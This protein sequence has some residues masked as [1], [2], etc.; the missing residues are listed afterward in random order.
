MTDISF[1][2]FN[3]TFFGIVSIWLNKSLFDSL[4]TYFIVCSLKSCFSVLL[5]IYFGSS[6][7][8]IVPSPTKAPLFIVVLPLNLF[9]VPLLMKVQ[10]FTLRLFVCLL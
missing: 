1:D 4:I 6:V 10:W 3:I 9:V 8:N 7:M 5:S 2:I